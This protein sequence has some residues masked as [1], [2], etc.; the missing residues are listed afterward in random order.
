MWKAQR[1]K[2]SNKIAMM[3]EIN[4]F[5]NHHGISYNLIRLTTS[6]M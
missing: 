3:E 4:T 5:P 6:Y 2:N 1:K